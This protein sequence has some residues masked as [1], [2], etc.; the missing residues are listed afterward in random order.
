M[1]AAFS[2]RIEVGAGRLLALPF[3][4]ADVAPSVSPFPA[5]SLL[6]V[7]MA[8]FLPLLRGPALSQFLTLLFW[9]TTF[10]RIMPSLF[11]KT[12]AAKRLLPRKV[13]V[14]SILTTTVPPAVVINEASTSTK[15]LLAFVVEGVF[16]FSEMPAN[17][18][19]EIAV[20]FT[21]AEGFPSQPVE[22]GSTAPSAITFLASLKTVVAG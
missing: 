4:A 6:P 13:T 15:L 8:P 1:R 21:V 7:V 18:P 5:C 14:R 16:A 3:S 11:F 12:V 10:I 20:P 9:Q 2:A 19:L 22:M 17:V